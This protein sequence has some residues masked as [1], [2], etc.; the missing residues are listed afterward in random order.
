MRNSVRPAATI[1][2][3]MKASRTSC[4]VRIE[5]DRSP[6]KRARFYDAGAGWVEQRRSRA[7]HAVVSLKVFGGLGEYATLLDLRDAD[8]QCLRDLNGDFV[9]Q[10][11]DVGER[12]IK[13]AGP[14]HAAG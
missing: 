9:L 2:A 8:G 10:H 4:I 11:E 7:Q 13:A 14:Q 5:L 6:Q 12:L 3:T 1:W